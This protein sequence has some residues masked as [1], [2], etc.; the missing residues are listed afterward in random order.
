MRPKMTIFDHM[1]LIAYLPVLVLAFLVGG[2]GRF[3]VKCSNR[4]FGK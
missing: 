2:L 1:K 4:V 3:L